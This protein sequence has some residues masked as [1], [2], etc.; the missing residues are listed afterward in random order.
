MLDHTHNSLYN[1]YNLSFDIK[2]DSTH[3]KCI[4]KEGSKSQK[5]I[6]IV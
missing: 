6:M 4:T 2:Y 5:V 3:I 1:T